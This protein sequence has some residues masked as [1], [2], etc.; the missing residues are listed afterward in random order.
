MNHIV[1]VAERVTTRDPPRVPF[2]QPKEYWPE[3]VVVLGS[4]VA[5]DKGSAL[6]RAGKRWGGVGIMVTSRVSWQMAD[7]ERRRFERFRKVPSGW[8]VGQKRWIGTIKPPK[9][10]AAEGK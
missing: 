1:W 7:E 10:D 6:W 3:E 2:M 4:V 8:V 9:A 5:A